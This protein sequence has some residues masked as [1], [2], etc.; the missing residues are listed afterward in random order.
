[1]QVSEFG[2]DEH[3]SL[4]QKWVDDLSAAVAVIARLRE[5]AN[6]EG[7]SYGAVRLAREAL[8]ALGADVPL[9]HSEI[10]REQRSRDNGGQDKHANLGS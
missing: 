4:Q 2:A 5:I 6:L 9:C 3:K 1:M 7:H 10:L 8:R